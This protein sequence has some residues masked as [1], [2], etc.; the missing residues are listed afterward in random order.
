MAL[1]RTHGGDNID[2]LTYTNG[3]YHISQNASPVSGK[4]VVVSFGQQSAGASMTVTSGTY[5]RKEDLTTSTGSGYSYGCSVFFNAS[6]LV[7]SASTL[8]IGI[9]N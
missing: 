9:F 4:V 3:G 1:I 5:D 8:S 6:N 7:L 2:N